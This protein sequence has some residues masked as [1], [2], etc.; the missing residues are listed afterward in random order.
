MLSFFWLPAILHDGDDDE[1]HHLG[2]LT[3]WTRTMKPEIQSSDKNLVEKELKFTTLKL[4]SSLA[5][6]PAT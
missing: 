4:M 6:L 3:P 1:E 5:K 2:Y